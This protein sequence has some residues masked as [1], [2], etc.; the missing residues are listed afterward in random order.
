MELTKLVENLQYSRT[1]EE[2]YRAFYD[3]F[4]GLSPSSTL[5]ISVILL[6]L[7]C[8]GMG[9]LVFA[10]RLYNYLKQWY[11]AKVTI[12]TT[13]P[14]FFNKQNVPE[15]DIHILL[16][17]RQRQCR[18]TGKFPT[19]NEL[20]DLIFVAPLNKDYDI[21][22]DDIS[23]LIPY[24][25][26]LNTFIFSEYND[27]A[28]KRFDFPTG[29]GGSRVGLMLSNTT[30]SQSDVPTSLA[31][32]F[33]LAYMFPLDRPTP[34]F[35]SF[36]ALVTSKY[37][38]ISLLDIV[39]PP[40]MPQHLRKASLVKHIFGFMYVEIYH[41]KRP[42][43]KFEIPNG[44]ANG[45]G[46]TLRIRGDILP[47]KNEIMLSLMRYSLPDVLLTG[48]QSITDCLSCCSE[49]NIWYQTTPWKIS[50][51]QSLAEYM[52]NEYLKSP[53]TSCG[54]L[55]ALNY[56]SD[57]SEFVKEW[58][59]RVRG[60]PKLDAIVTMTHEMKNS[61]AIQTLAYNVTKTSTIQSFQNKLPRIRKS[62][63]I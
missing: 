15:N 53:L 25:T 28:K 14:A 23:Q 41:R 20:Y 12:A 44:G 38:S 42:T 36:L 46:H 17:E 1:K 56:K 16:P 35:H 24:S 57:Y 47:V 50:L 6:T 54:S 55:D 63:N 43:V 49:K 26:R 58:D 2:L 19:I 7:P 37:N 60:R 10:F 40:W 45:H 61:A 32:D 11:N 39:V 22:Y 4:R 48:D 5:N 29:V 34:C 51:A 3:S 9:D 30:P 13:L 27:S 21:R 18:R 31:A 8:H 62:L 59:F 33:I 52:P